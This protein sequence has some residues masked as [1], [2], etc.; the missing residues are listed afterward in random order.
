MF[1]DQKAKP[2]EPAAPLLSHRQHAQAQ[3]REA[4]PEVAVDA[5][6]RRV[7]VYRRRVE[8]LHVVERDGRVDEEAEE[9]RAH[10]VP[11]GRGH[12]EVDG[13]LVVLDPRRAAR[14]GEVVVGLKAHH[15]QAASAPASLIVPPTTRMM[16]VGP[17][18]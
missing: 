10:E 14:H 2:M 3:Q 9:A 15:D 5:E 18:K 11:E 12:E 8:A 13:P 17:V 16:G 4:E 7:R 6:E 1:T